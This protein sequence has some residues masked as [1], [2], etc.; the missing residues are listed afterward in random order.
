VD[1]SASILHASDDLLDIERAYRLM[2][3]NAIRGKA[4]NL[5]SDEG[6][7][8]NRVYEI[9]GTSLIEKKLP[10]EKMYRMREEAEKVVIAH[11]R[12]HR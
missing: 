4:R 12:L 8:F 10:D 3:R 6:R 5:V 11:E 9:E 1:T 2:L 7:T